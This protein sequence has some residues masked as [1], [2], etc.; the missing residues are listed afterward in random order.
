MKNDLISRQA[1]IDAMY[2]LE[3]EDIETYGCSIPEGFDAKPAVEALEALP[4]AEPERIIKISQ[5][6]GKTLENAIDYLHSVGWLQEHDRI[7]TESAEPELKWIP[8]TEALPD[9][10]KDVLVSVHF[11]GYK[12]EYTNYPP[13]DYVEIASYI[14]GVWSSVY[15]EFK[16]MRRH[17]H[18][19][20]WM[21]EPK[22]W[23]GE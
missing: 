13:S 20:A 9:E 11:D 10:E 19:V 2:R 18:I 14:D 16:M 17:H 1:A 5:R 3:A 15:D 12:D 7:L 8:V 21:E 22:P 4:S 6:S 23:R